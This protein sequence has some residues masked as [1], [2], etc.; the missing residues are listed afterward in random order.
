MRATAGLLL[1]LVSCSPSGAVLQK[2][3]APS[4][5]SPT[6]PEL[7]S[8][9]QLSAA[10]DAYDATRY[11]D[12]EKLYQAAA[13]DP[14]QRALAKLGLMQLDLVQGRYPNV[15]AAEI[16]EAELEPDLK[17][18]AAVLRAHALRATG[19]LDQALAVLAEAPR[20]PGADEATL[21]HGEILI[22]QGDRAAGEVVLAALEDAYNADAIAEGDSDRLGFVARAE[23]L[24]QSPADAN[25]AFNEAEQAGNVSV[26][27]L[28]WRAELYLDNHDGAHAAEVLEEI[29]KRAPNHPE[30]LSLSARLR[31]EEALDFGAAE[32]LA[33][34]ALE[35]NPQSTH[36]RAVLGALR[37]R[38]M[39][40]TRAKQQIDAG[41][42][43]NPRSLP[44][45]SLLG[46]AAFL[47]DDRSQLEQLERRVLGLNAGYSAFYTTVGLYAE[48][49]HRYADIVELMLRAVAVDPVD[50]HAWAQLGLNQ[51]RGGDDT[52]GVE[53]L[54]TAFRLDPYNVRV[55]NTLDLF[56]HVI[57]KHYV[58]ADAGQFRIRY[59][60]AERALLQRY[61]PQLLGAAW[62]K[63][64]RSYD[65]TPKQPIGVELY[66]E[67]AHFAIRT[68]GL[69]DTAIQGVC[70]G[71]TLASVS[72]SNERFNLAMTLW[73]ELSHVFHIQLSQNHVPR[74]FTEGLA[75]YETL[76][77]RP[78]WQREG[79]P[80][81]YLALKEQRLPK[82]G[83]MNEAF[84]HAEELRDIAVAYYASTQIVRMLAEQFGQPK[85]REMLLLWG[86]GKRTDQ[87]MQES[88]GQTTQQLDER[89]QSYVRA[90]LARYDSQFVPTQ[91][92][93]NPEEALRAVRESDKDAGRLTRVARL[94]ADRGELAAAEHAL[95]VAL[96]ADPTHA[97]ALWLR[98]TIALQQG[99]GEAA[100]GYSA[101]LL[102]SGKDGYETQMLLA[103]SAEARGDSVG[104][105]RAF[106]AAYRFD[107]SERAA[108][109]ALRNI[110][111]RSGSRDA[112]LR[113]LR[114]LVRLEEHDGEAHRELM[115]LLLER[116]EFAEA[117][118]LGRA[119]VNADMESA[120]THLL[121]ARALE[122][123]GRNREAEY[124]Y[125]SAALCPGD[126][127]A[128]ARAEDAVADYWERRGDARRAREFRERSAARRGQANG[129]DE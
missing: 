48:W 86:K 20:V 54:R 30:A 72:P 102:S 81:L 125:T 127:E 40:L 62:E 93:G 56:E 12:A 103:R 114:E 24:L 60:A 115:S 128:V 59:P 41:L 28:L 106:E 77:E 38:D 113:W 2:S 27:T 67:R 96:K 75:E 52:G 126:D 91:R 4:R 6:V 129:G 90:R 107:P 64:V 104:A 71:Q 22:E 88:I 3:E 43:V 105:E 110:A 124:E 1:A 80:D 5:Q 7:T 51:I 79:D 31:I 92:V 118:E 44:L 101:R 50:G 83:A 25:Q 23:Q 8:E 112:E 123:L 74:W 16:G 85:L 46:A 69:P 122:E 57:P 26:Q 109:D 95:A 45:L 99:N 82:I 76:I 42:A 117:S 9:Q 39:D 89:F 100:D 49:E 55:Y 37:L 10:R 32:R 63:M 94:A 119:A 108:I 97:D 73:H 53:A 70:F 116:R 11:A 84:T 47:A 15:V 66:A 33:G 120:E 78:E 121:Y 87:V 58:T 61:V 36:A 111:K 35:V 14:S 68:S 98:A 18:A 17:T 65:F 19:S 34:R 21:L 13:R 29:I